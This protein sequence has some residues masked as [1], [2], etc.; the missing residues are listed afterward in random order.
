[1]V[2]DMLPDSATLYNH[3]GE[4]GNGNA[5][6]KRTFFVT[7]R[8]VLT[9]GAVMEKE[10]DNIRVYLFDRKTE[11]TDGTTACSYCDPRAFD[12]LVDKC[13]HWT[14]RDDGR[15]VI[16]KGICVGE[17]PPDD[18]TAFALRTI[19]RNQVGNQRMWHWKVT[20]R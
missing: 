16:A 20:G 17:Q 18:G 8:V 12:T 4:D 10:D 7:C 14:L 6:Y 13:A 3:L 1:M 15:D 9:V 5:I 2:I 11:A 19:K